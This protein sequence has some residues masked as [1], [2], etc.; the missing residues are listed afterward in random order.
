M[1]FRKEKLK[2][3]E[4]DWYAV[5]DAVGGIPVEANG[6]GMRSLWLA[7]L[8]QFPKVGSESAIAIARA[9]GSPKSLY[10]VRE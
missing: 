8:E 3:T 9:Y 4:F 6:K 7:Q 10:Q 5:A 2:S 1:L